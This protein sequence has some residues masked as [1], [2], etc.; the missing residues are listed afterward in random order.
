MIRTL[1]AA[2]LCCFSVSLV[3]ETP[4]KALPEPQAAIGWKLFFDTSLSRNN[5]ISCG[6][7]H[8]PGKGYGDGKRFGTGTHGDV[9]SRN[10]PSVVNLTEAEHFFWDGRAGSLEEQ[11]EGPI[12]NPLEMDLS[13]A[14]AEQRIAG[15]D[16][17]RRAFRRIGVEAPGIGDITAALAAFQRSLTT[18]ATAY[19][20]WLQGDAEA[21][22]E[23]QSNGRFLF[24]TRGQCAICHI[25]NE[26][27]DHE[28]HNIGTGTAEDPGRFA[29]TGAE[30]DRGAFKTPSI[31]NWRGKEPFMHDG[32]FASMEEVIAF[33][34]DPPPVEVGESELD[35]LRFSEQDQ[36]DLLAFMEA[37]NGAWPDLAAY[38]KAWDL[39]IS[40]DQAE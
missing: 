3:A 38:E 26:F 17:Y 15:Q 40:A 30:E 36:Q 20:R 35:P 32:R 12:T 34:T 37:L 10:T 25:G 6:S 14:E 4:D 13:L 11:A 18:G 28:F 16:M 5:N 24:F 27:S 1:L 19:D 23:A 22:T 31:R 7:C 2:A 29:V 9:L 39:L 8:D 33:Y 21:L